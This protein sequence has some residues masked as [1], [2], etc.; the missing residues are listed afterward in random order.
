VKSWIL[1]LLVLLLVCGGGQ[2]VFAADPFIQNYTTVPNPEPELADVFGNAVAPVGSE[3]FVVGAY[4][5]NAGGPSAGSAYLYEKDGTLLVTVTNPMTIY[6]QYFGKAVTGMGSTRFAVSAWDDAFG[7][8]NAGSVY[9]YGTNGTLVATVTN[10]APPFGDRFGCSI[11]G[12]NEDKLVIGSCRDDT[13]V[14][15][16][17]VAYIY[18]VSSAAITV[19]ITNPVPENFAQFGYTV[20]RASDDR[21][22]VGCYRH[23]EGGVE[24]GQAYLYD[25]SGNLL[26]TFTNPAPSSGDFFG[27]ALAAVGE[28]NILIGASGEDGLTSNIGVVY[29]YDTNANLLATVSNPTPE[30]YDS[31]GG[32]IT[33]LGENRF[34]V[35]CSG[36]NL[37]ESGAGS[38][39]L[40]DL[41]GNL[42]MTVINPTPGNDDQFGGG[43][44][45]LGSTVLAVGTPRDDHECGGTNNAGAVYVY[46]FTDTSLE[47]Y[48]FES[49]QQGWAK[50]TDS[51]SLCVTNTLRTNTWA[52]GGS[53]SLELECDL[54]TSPVAYQKGEAEVDMEH[55]PPDPRVQY[56]INLE[57][58]TVSMRVRCPAGAAGTNSQAWAHHRIMMF[59]KDQ[60]GDAYYDTGH[61]IPTGANTMDLYLKVSTNTPQPWGWMHPSFDP[62]EVRFIGLKVEMKTEGGVYNGPLYIDSIAFDALEPEALA[63]NSQHV[64]DMELEDQA[65][66]W[67]WDTNPD[68]WGARS[69]TNV[70]YATNEGVNGSVALAGDGVFDTAGAGDQR[71]AVFEI[72]YQPALNLSTKDHR[73]IQARLRFDPVIEGTLDFNATI[74]VFDKITDQ[75]Y[76]HN[77][78]VGGSGWNV[79]QFDLDNTNEYDSGSPVPMAVT[80]IGFI[81]I[82]LYANSSWTGTVYLDDVVVGG[83]ERGTDYVPLGGD[84]VKASG[85]KFT[86]GGTNFYHTG[87]NIEYLQTESDAVVDECLD[88]AE[89]KGIQVVRTWAMQE[90]QPYSFQPER[91]VWNELMFEHLDRI[92]ADAGDRKIRLMLAVV[93]N[94]AHNGG[95]FQYV[96]WVTREHPE[97]VN[98]NLNPEGVLYHDQFWT[99]QW[100]RQ[101]YKDYVTKLLNRTN[102]ITGVQY[103][104]DP[105]IFAWEIVNEPRCESDYSGGT[106]HEWLNTMS[107]W[108]RT[109]DTNHMLSGG[110]EGGYVN[111]YEHADTIPWEV[112]PDNYYHYGVYGKGSSTCDLYGCGRGHGVDFMSDYSSEPTYVEW[113]D[114]VW[115]NL[116]DSTVY[117][118][119]RVGN[120]NINFCTSRIYIDQKEYNLW[121]TNFN[122]CDQ[123]IEWI[124][125]H[126]WDA[127]YQ[128]GKPLVLEEFG[129]HA[130]G[131]VFNGSYGQIQ[132]ERTPSYDQQDRVDVYQLFYDYVENSG[133][134]G[135]YFWN[136]GFDGMWNDPFHACDYVSPWYA[137]SGDGSATGVVAVT[138]YVIEGSNSLA[139]YFDVPD[140]NHNKAIFGCPT[141]EMWVLRVDRTLTNDPPTRGINRGKF[142]WNFYNPGP[143]ISV[144]LALR[145]TV[146]NYWCETPTNRLTT[147]WTRVQFDLSAGDWA[148][149][150][151]GWEHR[152][153]LINIEADGTNV[154]EDVNEVNV[155]FYDLPNGSGVVYM[156]DVQIKRDD[157]FVVYADDPVNTVISN[158]AARMA[159]RNVATND[160]GNTAPS[161]P[162]FTIVADQFIATNV[163]IAGTDVEGDFLSYRIL[164]RPTNGWVFGVPPSNMIYKS[165]PG[166]ETPDQ[167]TYVIHDGKVDSSVATVTVAVGSTDIDGDSIPD[168]WEYG[169]FPKRVQWWPYDSNPL[170]N[171]FTSSDWDGDGFSDYREWGAGTDPTNASSYLYIMSTNY[172]VG[173]GIVLEWPSSAGKTYC[174]ER[175]TNLVTGF[176]SAALATNIAAVAPMN[177]YTDTTAVGMGP[178]LYRIGVE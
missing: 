96:H 3:L 111:T 113:Q 74:S 77:E 149:E 36:D 70:Y 88:W 134:A 178:Y 131:W 13:G 91:G 146:S 124:N 41:A 104:D 92:V 35:G 33:P 69:W 8:T 115:S 101:W 21:L 83:V 121:R 114:G 117:G 118:E 102:T 150:G 60:E 103:K 12:L 110:E 7:N 59:V 129:I 125:D 160:P 174:V 137:N 151:N 128:I 18:D 50:T 31:F 25:T 20:A 17:G 148:W 143:D 29:V 173:T 61:G 67:K 107:D 105:T 46:T 42:L 78:G 154:L 153:Y 71:K 49:D 159:E 75:W 56:P 53:Y 163:I 57:G 136:F 24:V 79:L 38:C 166:N 116:G 133:M 84:F 138:N 34:V 109:I 6:T 68:G 11:A 155:I 161:A 27:I 48:G 167:F 139:L 5:D 122:D 30:F 10:P 86:V 73:K 39:Y 54:K 162:S 23:E 45:G 62:T 171:L 37:T 43:V 108:V 142:F 58:R 72:A 1:S 106:I 145:G 95:M 132:L 81:N 177:T 16:S 130:N 120:S 15:D 112:Y 152:D 51:G 32:E 26:Q 157:G 93:D 44:A 87:A 55:Y 164:E 176:G 14:S 66:W 52:F 19:T 165:K 172:M 158:H 65:R 85:H 82:Q 80:A 141:N 94:W 119:W 99:N 28:T 126:W 170:S 156:D 76:T 98:T 90:G 144:A 2:A 169:F 63:T 135:S 127:H 9:V 140:T 89:S 100:C 64:Y 4:L 97:S 40:Y 147:G 22:L 175:S 47:R 168:A 123:R